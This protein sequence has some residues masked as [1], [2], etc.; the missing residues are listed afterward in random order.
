[1]HRDQLPIALLSRRLGPINPVL[2]RNLWWER[3][4]RAGKSMLEV[5]WKR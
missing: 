5:L 1:M 2:R 3:I 4:K